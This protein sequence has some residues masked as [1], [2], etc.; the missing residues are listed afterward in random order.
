[1]EIKK[2]RDRAKREMLNFSVAQKRLERAKSADATS[3]STVGQK[4]NIFFEKLEEFISFIFRIKDGRSDVLVQVYADHATFERFGH[5]LVSSQNKH[6]HT[7]HVSH[8]R[9]EATRSARSKTTAQTNVGHDAT[10]HKASHNKSHTIVQASS[11]PST[12]T[13]VV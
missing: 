3:R 13:T 2:A 8:R 4:K 5:D 7:A 9:H 6:I 1:M 10:I 11:R 12:T